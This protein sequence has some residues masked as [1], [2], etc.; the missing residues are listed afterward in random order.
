M[1]GFVVEAYTQIGKRY[2]IKR[3]LGLSCAKCETKTIVI[4]V[5]VMVIL[6][7]CSYNTTNAYYCYIYMI[8]RT[9]MFVVYSILQKEHVTQIFDYKINIYF[10]FF[11]A[12][13]WVYCPKFGIENSFNKFIFYQLGSIVSIRALHFY[14]YGPNHLAHLLYILLF[15]QIYAQVLFRC[16]NILSCQLLIYS[17]ESC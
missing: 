4:V 7:P 14:G 6:F 13:C 15:S 12:L 8:Y 5:M 11:C 1:I 9:C 17:P 3:V 2:K 10:L 16:K